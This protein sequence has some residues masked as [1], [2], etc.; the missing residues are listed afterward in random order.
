MTKIPTYNFQKIGRKEKLVDLI[1]WDDPNFYQVEKPH[2]HE[3]HEIFVILEGNGLHQIDGTIYPLQNKSFQIVPHFFSHQFTRDAESKGFTVAI[4]NV[5]IEQL[6]RFD[7][8]SNYRALFEKEH[9]IHLSASEFESFDFFL[10]EIQKLEINDAYRQNICAAIL[11]KLIPFIDHNLGVENNFSRLVRKALENN[12]MKRLSTEQY[13]AMFNLTA[14]NLNIKVKKIAGKTIMQMQDDL[15]ITNVKRLLYNT[16][17]DL[18]D[19]AFE[20]GFNDYT[21]FS[22]F[23]KKHTGISPIGYRKGIKNIQEMNR[24]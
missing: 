22:H 20:H 21:H 8:D 24:N 2:C 13:A 14:L 15:L 3:Y 19:I 1:V 9:M 17:I 16:D 18:K 10:N 4:T 23:F 5:F 11:L 7:S 6:S 12:F